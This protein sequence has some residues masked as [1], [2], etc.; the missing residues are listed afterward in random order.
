MPCLLTN[1]WKPGISV[2]EAASC[3]YNGVCYNCWQERGNF[4][5]SIFSL[6]FVTLLQEVCNLKAKEEPQQSGVYKLFCYQTCLKFFICFF[7][8]L[9]FVAMCYYGLFEPI[10][11][12]HYSSWLKSKNHFIIQIFPI[13]RM[14]IF[15]VDFRFH[16]LP[17][18]PF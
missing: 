11:V 8:S 4:G 7:S 12:F 14:H 16:Q 2:S 10:K 1:S 17:I 5:P 9:S 3:Y 15:L 6:M 13:Y 18:S